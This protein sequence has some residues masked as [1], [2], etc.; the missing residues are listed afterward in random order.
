[1]FQAPFSNVFTFQTHSDEGHLSYMSKSV[2]ACEYVCVCVNEC[3]RGM[4]RMGNKTILAKGLGIN[5]CTAKDRKNKV[6]IDKVRGWSEAEKI[7]GK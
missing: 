5:G 7:K 4:K 1:M 3:G 6:K 2:S